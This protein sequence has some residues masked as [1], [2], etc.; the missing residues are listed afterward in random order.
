MNGILNSIFR[1]GC[2]SKDYKIVKGLDMGIEQ[3]VI[4]T[5]DG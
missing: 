4:F 1:I 2:V 3:M 5:L